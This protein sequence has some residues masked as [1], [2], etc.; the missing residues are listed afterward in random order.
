MAHFLLI[1]DRAA[2]QLIR[3]QEYSDAATAIARRFEAENEFAGQSEIEIVA[4]SAGSE[5]ELRTTHARYFLDLTQLAAR[6]G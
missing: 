5:D 2:G 3:Q 6:I 4:V 1:Y